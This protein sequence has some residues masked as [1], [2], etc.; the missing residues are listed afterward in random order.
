MRIRYAC[1]IQVYPSTIAPNTD[2]TLEDCW[3]RSRGLLPNI[4]RKGCDMLVISVAWIIWK[5]RN[6]RVVGNMH[7]WV[8]EAG[9]TGSNLGSN[10]THLK[11]KCLGGYLTLPL[12]GLIPAIVVGHGHGESNL[13]VN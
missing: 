13:R 3:V 11:I 7:Q 12:I 4:N 8:N 1:L 2:E 6:A 5:Q 10:I 9:H